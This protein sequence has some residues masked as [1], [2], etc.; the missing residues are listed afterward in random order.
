MA[1]HDFF[2]NLEGKDQPAYQEFTPFEYSL[3]WVLH[4]LIIFCTMYLVGGDLER[5]VRVFFRILDPLSWR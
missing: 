1:L 5:C 4:L 2:R 3:F